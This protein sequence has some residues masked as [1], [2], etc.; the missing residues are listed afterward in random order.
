M[1]LAVLA[2][3][4]Q[5]PSITFHSLQKGPAADQLSNLPDNFHPINHASALSD[6][7]ES[8]ALIA[9]LDLVI[10]VDTSVAHLAGALGKPVWLMLP[11]AA[12]WRWLIDRSDS[13]WYPTMRIFRQPARGDWPAV[14]EQV[15][16]A[17]QQWSCNRTL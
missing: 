9:H 17:L 12:D 4:A 15:K 11:F 16:A 7:A 1:P 3:L 6:F 8:A 13:P 10:S 2:P 5:I 14:V